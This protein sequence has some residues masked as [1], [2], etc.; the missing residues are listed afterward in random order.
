MLGDDEFKEL[1]HH[2][3][4]PWK[5]YRKVRKGVIKRLRHHMKELDCTSLAEYLEIVEQSKKEYQRCQDCLRVTIS[6]FFRDRELWYSLRDR[7]LPRLLNTWPQG[8]NVW[9]G[10]CSCGEEPY[11]L[12]IIWSM[13]D[14]PA[15]IRI[16]ATDADPQCLARARQGL[17]PR[18]SLKELPVDVIED[19]FDRGGGRYNVK[20]SL[21]E[22]IRWQRRD[23]LAPPPEGPFQIVFLRNNLLTYYNRPLVD[24]VLESIAAQLL[25][26]GILIIGT[27]EHLPKLRTTFRQDRCSCIYQKSEQ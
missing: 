11:S 15:G 7:L 2:F 10:G 18:S 4:R 1:L 27:H 6:R 26:G 14:N 23:L 17:Y 13:L 12:A 9:S 8:L 5:G 25:P 20:Q 16:L 22:D 24:R 21:Q 19:Y 3:N